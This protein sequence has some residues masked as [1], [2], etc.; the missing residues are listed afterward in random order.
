MRKTTGGGV[1]RSGEDLSH[2]RWTIAGQD[3]RMMALE[4]SSFAFEVVVEP[5]QA[6]PTH[7]HPKQDAFMLVQFGRLAVTLDGEEI[8]AGP[9]DLVRLPRGLP[10]RHE[11]RSSG[12]AKALFW[13]SPALR[14][15]DLFTAI[16]GL[17][18]PREILRVSH[19]YGV[20]FTSPDDMPPSSR[21]PAKKD[22]REA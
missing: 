22:R 20:E 21:T 11:N 8:D 18:D 4:D 17:S 7:L 16:E 19:A 10:H 9:G 5:G 15:A 13:V 2:G 1:T 6:V 14:L 12:T 3:C